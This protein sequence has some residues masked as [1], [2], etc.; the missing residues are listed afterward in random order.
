[1]WIEEATILPNS[2][3]KRSANPGNKV[4]PPAK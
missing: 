4:A 3:S 1:M 2:T